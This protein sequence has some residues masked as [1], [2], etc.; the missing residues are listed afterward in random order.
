GPV[1]VDGTT[2]LRAKAF[3]ADMTPSTSSGGVYVINTGSVDRP[4]FQPGAGRY[5]TFQDVI[6]TT[7]T[8]GATI[9]YTTNGQEP[10]TSDPIVASGGTVHVD[11][12]MT[13]RAKAW[14]TGMTT[15]APG[16][17]EYHLTGAIATGMN[18]SMA[19]KVD[20]TVWV[21]G[22]NTNGVFGDSAVPLSTNRSTAGIVPGLTDVVAIA[23]GDRHC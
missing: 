11:R 20:G 7:Q 8:A 10:T 5:T 21:W 6:V 9:R 4:R 14:K 12:T 22:Q 1:S 17:A 13:L 18:H 23:S 3:H 15:S 19:L 16:H 2:D